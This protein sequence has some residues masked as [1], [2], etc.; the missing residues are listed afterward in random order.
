MIKY[1]L[2]ILFAVCFSGCSSLNT[3]GASVTLDAPHVATPQ[4][5]LPQSEVEAGSYAVNQIL[6]P[7]TYSRAEVAAFAPGPVPETIR[8]EPGPQQSQIESTLEALGGVAGTIP[9]GQ[10]YGLLL[11]GAA[12]IAKIWRDS[13]T[14]KDTRL[15]AQTLAQARDSSLDIIATLPDRAQAERLE[16][17][18]NEH[19]D[20]FARKLGKTR[21]LLDT[22]LA[23]TATPTKKPIHAS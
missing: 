3:P 4:G 7:G 5:L 17:Q 1:L 12:S 9:G 13:R 6:Q 21:Q 14:I 18:I 20:E 11:L 10:P 19:I 16:R 2:P 23:E 15:V 22:I 8:V